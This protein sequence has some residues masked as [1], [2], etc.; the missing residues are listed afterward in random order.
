MAA[1][2]QV[3]DL[4]TA[5]PLVWFVKLGQRRAEFFGAF[6]YQFLKKMGDF[7]GI[8]AIECEHVCPRRNHDRMLDLV[9]RTG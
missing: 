6:T 7:G 4:I 5:A 8:N 3:G 2:Y 1:T 9:V